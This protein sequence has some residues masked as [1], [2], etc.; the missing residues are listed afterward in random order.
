MGRKLSFERNVKN[1]I[2][3]ANEKISSLS[4]CCVET[5]IEIA[6]LTDWKN[7]HVD[8]TNDR[9]NE[10]ELRQIISSI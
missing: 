6:F 8:G 1:M 9:E 2:F 10:K 3:S 4:S 5:R 7:F